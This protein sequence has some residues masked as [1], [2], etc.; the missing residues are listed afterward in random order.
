MSN[1]T[2][3]EL[4][5]AGPKRELGQRLCDVD[6]KYLEQCIR[7]NYWHGRHESTLRAELTRRHNQQLQ[8]ENGITPHV[9]N[10]F[11]A[12]EGFTPYTLTTPANQ[13]LPQQPCLAVVGSRGEGSKHVKLWLPVDTHRKLKIRAAETGTTLSAMLLNALAKAYPEVV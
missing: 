10:S 7:E 9:Y 11:A 12:A 2:G 8:A 1:I 5:P 13:P 6:D 4:F 3:Y